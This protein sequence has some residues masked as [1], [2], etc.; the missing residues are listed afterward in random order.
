MTDK[1]G[2]ELLPLAKSWYNPPDLSGPENLEGNYDPAQ[3]AYVLA[4]EGESRSIEFRIKATQESPVVNPAFVIRNWEAHDITLAVNGEQI[5]RGK[6]F[7]VGT[8]N[9]LDSADLV[10]WIQHESTETVQILFR[11]E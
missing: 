10:V 6:D 9:R 7:R 4:V 3:R 5:P 2:G 11:T 8:I 1:S